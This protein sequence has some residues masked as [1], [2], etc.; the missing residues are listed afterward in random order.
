MPNHTI[1]AGLQQ[2]VTTICS[3]YRANEEAKHTIRTAVVEARLSSWEVSDERLV[4]L[5][6]VLYDFLGRVA[7]NNNGAVNSWWN[8]PRSWWNK[9]QSHWKKNQNAQQALNS[10]MHKG[11]GKG[12]GGDGNK[13]YKGGKGKGAEK[14]AKG[15]GKGKGAGKGFGKGA[16]S[17]GAFKGK[18]KGKSQN[19]GK[20]K[21]NWQQGNDNK[22]K[23]KGTQASSQSAVYVTGA[24][25]RT[26][27]KHGR[28]DRGNQCTYAHD[29]RKKNNAPQC[30]YYQRGSCQNGERCLFKHINPNNSNN[31][32]TKEDFKK[33]TELIGQKI[34]NQG[35]KQQ[36]N[37][38]KVPDQ[39]AGTDT[40]PQNNAQNAG[41]NSGAQKQP[42]AEIDYWDL[43]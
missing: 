24:D 37:Q 27:V 13:G 4:N 7:G 41:S 33:F 1:A 34:A 19:A 25:C 20:G 35:V 17:G 22:G 11:K 16:D 5:Y 40:K 32:V 8:N 23:G 6:A 2:A 18:G 38:R 21:G 43:E 15:K 29:E 36:S 26:L 31:A 28:C 12:A 39:N 30:L 42:N 9:P 10:Q 14:G 3:N